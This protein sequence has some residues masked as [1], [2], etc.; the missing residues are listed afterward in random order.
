MNQGILIAIE[1]IDG[2]GKTTQVDLLRRFLEDHNQACV[3]SKEPTDGPWGKKIRATASTGRLP[4]ADEL[5]LF[6]NDRQEHI[7][8]LISPALQAGKIVILDRYFYSTIAYQGSRGADWRA[9]EEMMRFAPVPD[10]TLILDAEPDMTLRRITNDRGDEPNEFEKHGSLSECR[11][12]FLELRTRPEVHL[13]DATR[14][15]DDV[16][17]QI[18]DVLLDGVLMSKRCGKSYGCD[19]HYCSLRATNSCQWA[20]MA[21]EI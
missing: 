4:L 12:V 9:V 5:Q 10:A 1:G 13:I 2:A 21:S 16:Q 3:T 17:R 14:S 7:K 6:V 20:L 18:M 11:N 19:G 8:T 15:V